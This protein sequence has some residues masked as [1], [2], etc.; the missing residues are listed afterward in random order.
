M[1]A[2]ARYSTCLPST[3]PPPR[4]GAPAVRRRALV[5]LCAVPVLLAALALAGCGPGSVGVLP[6]RASLPDGLMNSR[7]KDAAIKELER[8]AGESQKKAME[9]IEKRR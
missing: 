7:Q 4:Q 2:R 9:T 6:Q 3:P 8:S 5:R 1:R